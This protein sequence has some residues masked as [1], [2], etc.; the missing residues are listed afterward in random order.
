MGRG[1]VGSSHWRVVAWMGVGIMTVMAGLE[2]PHAQLGSELST[3]GQL[4]SELSTPNWAQSSPCPTGLRAL[5]AQLGSE[6][7]TPG[8]ETPI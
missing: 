1:R 5:H 3:P 8:M 6:L 4:G 2:V 7:P